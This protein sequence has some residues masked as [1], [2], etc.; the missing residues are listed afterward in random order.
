MMMVILRS[1]EKET[2]RKLVYQKKM[3]KGRAA[4]LLFSSWVSLFGG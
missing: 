4:V 3:K 1:R 2:R